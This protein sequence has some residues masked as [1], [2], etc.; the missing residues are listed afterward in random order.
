MSVDIMEVVS[1]LKDMIDELHGMLL[2]M[3]E[4]QDSIQQELNELRQLSY[5]H[6]KDITDL[7]DMVQDEP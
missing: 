5:R 6:C 3:S 1:G 2:V 4:H 7:M